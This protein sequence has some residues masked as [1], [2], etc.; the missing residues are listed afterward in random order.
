M[1][2]E[3][4]RKY[5]DSPGVAEFWASYKSDLFK[6]EE[7]ILA[8]LAGQI[9]GKPLLEIGVGAGRT[10]PYLR[11]LA[12]DYTGIDI[13]SRMVEQCRKKF[14]GAALFICDARDMALFK[15]GQF[16]T[17]VFWMNGIDEVDL[18]D[19]IAILKEIARVLRRGGIFLLSSHNLD[20]DGLAVSCA[21]DG[22]AFSG[23]PLRAAKSGVQRLIVYFR[24][25]FALWL[26]RA[27]RRGYVIFPQY[28]ESPRIN[29]PIFFIRTE[30]QERQ[31]KDVGFVQIEAISSDGIPLDGRNR[32]QDFHVYYVARKP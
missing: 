31:L 6:A 18:K 27:R 13:S 23:N 26:E 32:H 29:M 11:D 4:N 20:W 19:R 16:S 14:S 12:G 8:S 25:L 1:I 7:V 3:T 5:Y 17:V 24:C 30:A 2:S 21:F 15:D 28:E 9:K 22:F 10:T